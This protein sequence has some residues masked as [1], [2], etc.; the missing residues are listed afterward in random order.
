[1]NQASL[2]RRILLKL[3]GE[4]LM[5]S[6]AYGLEQDACIQVAEMLKNLV[7]QGVEPAV[8][9]GG[10]NI[11]R[12]VQGISQGAER[13]IS[14]QVGMLATVMNGLFLKQSLEQL[15]CPC[16]VLSA[17]PSVDHVEPFSHDRARAYLKEG[18]VVVFVGGL[19]HPYFTTDTTSAVRAC[20]VGAEI[21]LKATQVDGV[22]SADP[23][24]DPKAEKFQT[25]S[26]CEALEKELRIM[27]S[28]AFAVCRDNGMPI[29]VHSFNDQNILGAGVLRAIS[30]KDYGT[31]IQGKTT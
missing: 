29:R 7:D 24:R 16:S 28:T 6:Q 11:F 2:Y 17:I 8:V 5:G 31:L 14:D 3:S 26:Y 30:E 12:G 21:L 22:Y 4:S 15:G 19:G 20:Q 9:I 27:D 25:L 1:M 18:Q 10:G 13:T 23:K